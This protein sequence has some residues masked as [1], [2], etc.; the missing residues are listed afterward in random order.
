[1]ELTARPSNRKGL[2]WVLLSLFLC[3][4]GCTREADPDAAL[5]NRI[6]ELRERTSPPG[7]HLANSSGL[8]RSQFSVVASWEFDTEWG[9]RRYSPWVK[10]QLAAF[11]V[12]RD[13][14]AELVFTR[15]AGGDTESISVA[16]LSTAPRLRVQ[17]SFS[18]YPQ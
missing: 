2:L 11:G 10:S 1:M 4:P 6:A 15:P 17:V 9:W 13:N 16:A 18:I 12:L 3:L 8:V 5:R 14:G 7:S